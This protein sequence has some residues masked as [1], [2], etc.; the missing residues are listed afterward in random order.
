MAIARLGS[1]RGQYA[2]CSS[3]D[4][5][6]YRLAKESRSSKRRIDLAV[7]SGH[8]NWSE[9]SCYSIQGNGQSMVMTPWQMLEEAGEIDV[10][11]SSERGNRHD[12]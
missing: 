11:V 6:G 5:R 9:P 1:A 10:E 12:A 4:A 2:D 3:D 8:G 7:A